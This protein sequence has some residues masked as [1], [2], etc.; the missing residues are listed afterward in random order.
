MEAQAVLSTH[1]QKSKAA[2][3]K[4][5]YVRVCGILDI[6]GISIEGSGTAGIN[7]GSRLVPK[8]KAKK[9]TADS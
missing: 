2:V 3:G 6:Y 8:I 4:R 1:F 7:K 9:L 5:I